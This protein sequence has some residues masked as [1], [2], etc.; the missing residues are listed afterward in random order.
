MKRTTTN[1][2]H[3]ERRE[4]PRTLAWFLHWAAGVRSVARVSK[5]LHVTVFRLSRGFVMGRW[6]G[7]PVLVIETAGRRS[8]RARRTPVTFCPFDGR[9]IVLAI[10]GGSD[11][12]PS[13]WLNVRDAPESRI[14]VRGRWIAVRAREA[15]GA[16]RECLWQ[17]YA[18]QT[19][20]IDEF[21]N[22]T[23][24]TIP[25]VVLEPL[26]EGAPR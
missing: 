20:I 24:R 1:E 17:R 5:G 13:W 16:E 14:L 25:V 23:A 6:F 21:R 9:W 7:A 11:W 18:A 15:Q 12:T 2:K 4:R 10:N 3:R 19:P 22:Y 26:G 8:G